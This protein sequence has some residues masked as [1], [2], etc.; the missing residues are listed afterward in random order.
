MTQTVTARPAASRMGDPESPGAEKS[1]AGPP[2]ISIWSLNR[3]T[4][5]PMLTG[6]LSI[7][8][9]VIFPV[10]MPVVRPTLKT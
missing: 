5:S 8:T 9:D 1:A 4:E 2:E 3:G 10:E 7:S 6:R